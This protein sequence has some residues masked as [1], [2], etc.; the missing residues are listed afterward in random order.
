MWFHPA[1]NE[2]GEGVRLERLQGAGYEACELEGK[3]HDRL[4]HRRRRPHLRPHHYLQRTAHATG[5]G[6]RRQRH[7]RCEV[8]RHGVFL[9]PERRLPQL[10]SEPPR[11]AHARG[12]Q[13]KVALVLDGHAS[14]TTFEAISLAISLDI[15]LFQLPS[16]PSHMTQPLDV[17]TLGTFKKQMTKV[18]NAYPL[19]NGGRSPGKRD[20]AGVIA[21][22]WAGS[23]TPLNNS[24]SFRG[25]G[26]WPVDM[27]KALGRLHSTRKQSASDRPIP[28]D[29]AIVTSKEK[30]EAHLGPDALK[31]LK[32][33]GYMIEGFRVNTVLL[34]GLFHLRKR[35]KKIATV[36]TGAVVK[37]GGVMT[38]QEVLE[39][40]EKLD[41][42]KKA[43]EKKKEVNRQKRAE[44]KAA[45]EADRA[46]GGGRGLRDTDG[47]RGGRWCASGRREGRTSGQG[48]WG[49]PAGAR[50]EGRGAGGREG[51]VW[52][53]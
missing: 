52:G 20:M 22:A 14:H 47:G 17:G 5:L 46:N 8:H 30:L 39:I 10:P 45:K 37:D 19:Q 34:D 16:H 50:G 33:R 25:V 1:R 35:S 23:F 7:P 42:E 15:D 6:R 9:D 49:R 40:Y 13:G 27:E 18:L 4:H 41:H 36:R 43:A 24:S 51:G 2:G 44:R 3:H 31:E 53:G 48:G 32:E 11:T 21:Q 28:E 12:L 29:L 38:R 26:L